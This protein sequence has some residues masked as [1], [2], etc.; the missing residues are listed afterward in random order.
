M[1]KVQ[2]EHIL[3]HVTYGEQRAALR[4]AFMKEKERRRV[5]IG[6]YLTFLFENQATVRYQ[7]QEMVHAERIV[8]EADIRHEIETYNELLGGPGELGCTLLIEIDD[9]ALRADKL[10]AWR[11]LPGHLY[12]RLEDGTVVR[13]AFDERQLDPRRLSAVQ[14]LKFRTGGKVPASVGCDHPEL[15][16]EAALGEEQRAALQEDLR[17]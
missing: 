16:G 7:I 14:Y 1:K 6:E 8:R 2:R 17:E 12:V 9:P 11:A 15:Y 3:D 4:P 10:S 5:R 13:A